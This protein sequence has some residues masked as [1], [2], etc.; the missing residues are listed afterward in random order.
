MERKVSMRVLVI[1]ADGRLGGQI[2]QAAEAAG[3]EV[4]RSTFHT[5][6]IT[7]PDAVAQVVSDAAPALVIHAAAWTDVDGCAR[8][9]EKALV[10]NGLASGY[11]ARAAS[12]A[13]AG[14]AY[15][16]TNEVFSGESDAPYT[17]ADTPAP[18]NPYGYSKWVGEVAV[19]H[20]NINHF[21]MRTSWLFAPGSKNFA[22]AVLAR[23]AAGQPLRVVT[24]EVASPSYAIDVAQAVVRVCETGACGT[25]HLVNAGAASRYDFAR[26]LLDLAGHEETPI[27][28][29]LMRDWPRDSR[30]PRFSPLANTR[31]AALGITLPPW[32]DALAAF[33]AAEGI[34][35]A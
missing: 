20:A 19:R 11:V 30:P 22:G 8:D 23:A 3:H 28:P 27:E 17:E 14:I 12:L 7:R 13:G 24:D 31:A 34:N 26:A 29:I 4:Q 35:R 1:G 25:Y 18:V 10:Q 9:P 21:I 2:V 5:L 16:S 15:I 6:D 32:R 33:L